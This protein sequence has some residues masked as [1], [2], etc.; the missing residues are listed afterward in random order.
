MIKFLP[1]IFLVFS[2]S[3][4]KEVVEDN[5]FSVFYKND[6]GGNEK[7]S[8]VLIQDN[9]SYIKL[10]ESLK[11]DETEFSKFL[12]VD[13]KKK[14]VLV[15]YQGQKNTGGYAIDIE[16]ISKVNN[17]IHVKKKEITPK[18]GDLVTTALTSPFCIALIPKGNTIIIE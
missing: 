11:I 13:F 12:T 7:P 1:I 16:S 2:C 3:T 14:N 18:K 10:I 9:E 5:S 15:L 6:Y 17:T 4:P 8:H